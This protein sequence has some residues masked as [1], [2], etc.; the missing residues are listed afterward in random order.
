MVHV[1]PP[2]PRDIHVSLAS[3]GTAIREKVSVKLNMRG[4]NRDETRRGSRRAGYDTRW[5]GRKRLKL[6]DINPRRRLGRMPPKSPAF[7]SI[8]P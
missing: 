6:E 7:E 2:A 5:D 8:F 1:K 3:V 4:L